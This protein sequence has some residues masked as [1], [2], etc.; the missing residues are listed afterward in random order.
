MDDDVLSLTTYYGDVIAGGSFT[1]ADGQQALGIARWNG[2]TWL[3]LGAGVQIP[4]NMEG[5]GVQALCRFGTELIVGG[6][7]T[8]AGNLQTND[9]ARWN[10]VGWS[11]FGGSV[12]RVIAFTQLGSRLVAG[13]VFS[14]STSEYP[15]GHIVAWDGVGMQ[16]LGSG[17]D[18]PVFALKSFEHPGGLGPYE[19]IAGGSFNYSSGTLSKYIARWI[20]DPILG[21]E[22]QW[23]AMGAGFNNAVFAIERFGNQTYAGGAFNY[24]TGFVNRIARWNESTD[25]WEPLGSG[26]NGPVYALKDYGGYL[27]AGG[28]FTTAGGVATGG[29]ARWNGSSWSQVGGNFLGTVRALEVHNGLLVMAGSYPGIGGSPNIAQ[30]NGISYSTLGTGGTNG[31]VGALKSSGGLLYMGGEFTT[32][33]GVPANL[34][35]VWNGTAWSEVLG[36]ADNFVLTLGSYNGEVQVGG[37]FDKLGGTLTSRGW[38]RYSPTG[39]PWMATNP[40]PQTKTSGQDASFSA[41]VATGYSG[42]S[43][44]WYRNGTAL[45]DNAAAEAAQATTISGATT[46]YLSLYNVSTADAG[47]YQLIVKNASGRDSSTLARLTVDGTTDATNAGPPLTSVFRAI[48][49]NPTTGPSQLQYTLARESR[50]RVH[51]RDVAGRRVRD[52][53]IGRMPPGLHR[54]SWDG[55][56][57][58]GDLAKTGLYFVELEAEGRPVGMHRLTL[59]R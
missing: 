33:G 4:P 22:P 29:L 41:L 43:Y 47:Y 15:A 53:E 9:L 2:T 5:T 59:L 1:L 38:A 52:M 39:I 18:N 16:A 28:S 21:Y 35:A 12:T 7:F 48:G 10:G 44:R 50:V 23:S 45:Y 31:M 13:G 34:L 8:S 19:L 30:Y 3:R 27:Y 37:E 11:T 46:P 57:D 24:S 6:N 14:Q 58:S 56:A 49:P 40:S 55:R 26:M 32:A 36:G 42:L 20:E 54:S 51:V 25:L 17:M